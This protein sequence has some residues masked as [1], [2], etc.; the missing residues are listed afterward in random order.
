MSFSQK[1]IHALHDRILTKSGSWYGV[2]CPFC[3]DSTKSNKPHLFLYLDEKNDGLIGMKCF[4]PKCDIST[5]MDDEKAVKLGI[6]DRDIISFLLDNKG[7]FNK[8]VKQ[9]EDTPSGIKLKVDNILPEQIVYIKNRTEKDFSTSTMIRKYKY[10]TDVNKFLKDN[11]DLI[12]N[13]EDTRFELLKKMDVVGFL[14]PT[15]TMLH[16]RNISDGKDVMK[17][18]RIPLIKLPMYAEHVPYTIYQNTKD[19]DDYEEYHRF[20]GEGLF[21]VIN[22]S[23]YMACDV[24]GKFVA[25]SSFS[26]MRG[27]INRE[28]LFK[29]NKTEVVIKDA[30]ISV[31]MI[32]SLFKPYGYRLKDNKITYIYNDSGKDFGNIKDEIKP[33][34]KT[35]TL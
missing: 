30:D 11:E 23:I 33:M 34:K 5:I 18:I 29:P 6:F 1:I 4:Q 8:I 16:C 9:L 28:T 15:H 3:G 24:K 19:D 21:D 26:A 27:I 13:K 25:T 17:H 32:K 7:K 10:V 20:Y 31:N 14:N 12:T 22:T 35:I 2:R